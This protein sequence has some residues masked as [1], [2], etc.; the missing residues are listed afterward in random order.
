MGSSAVASSGASF[1][2]RLGS[3]S[4]NSAVTGILARHRIARHH[5]QKSTIFDFRFVPALAAVCGSL[6]HQKG[7]KRATSHHDC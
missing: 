2:M 1:A 5:P 4:G 7:K 3:L 6:L